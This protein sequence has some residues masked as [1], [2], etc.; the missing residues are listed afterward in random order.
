MEEVKCSLYKAVLNRKNIYPKNKALYFKGKYFTYTKLIRRINEFSYSLLKLGYKKGDVITLLLPN[1]PNTIYL[2]YAIN[3][4]GAIANLIHPLLPNTQV[5]KIMDKAGSKVLFALDTRYDE[6]KDYK[7]INVIPVSPIDESNVILKIGYNLLNRKAL[8]NANKAKVRSKDLF[9]KYIYEEYDNDYIADRIYLQSSGTSGDSKTI[10]LSSLS[11][12]SLVFPFNKLLGLKDANGTYILSTLPI[13]H[14]FGLSMGIHILLFYGGCDMLMPKFSTKETI[15]LIHKGKMTF[16]IGI[17]LLYEALLKNPKFKGKGF[18]KLNLAFVGGDYTSDSLKERFNKVMEE[19]NSICR[20]YE[21]YGLTETASVVSVNTHLDNK[22]GS[23]GK[24]LPGVDVKI[25]NSNNEVTKN[26]IEGEICVTGNTLM[27]GYRFN[28][29]ENYILIDG[30]KYFK[31]GDYGY[32]DDDNFLYFKQRIKR[33]IK[34]NGINVFP[35]EIE[36][37]LRKQDFVYDACVISVKDDK[38]GNLPVIYLIIKKNYPEINYD[39]QIKDAIKKS[40]GV[41]ALP[42][43]IVYVKEFKKNMIGKTDVKDLENK[44]N[45]GDLKTF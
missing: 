13:F 32:L 36:K 4:I 43:K 11:I 1:F 44:E 28:G 22:D 29:N 20:L 12:N 3:Q 27:N 40:L 23:V 18:D 37:I 35:S 2:L 16:M 10:A 25:V 17:P 34:V 8:K 26:F 24:V 7:D 5:K 15:K 39:E 19:N 41:Y 6:F 30:K 45:N 14:T 31:T 42:K 21:G 33:I 38:H 9:S